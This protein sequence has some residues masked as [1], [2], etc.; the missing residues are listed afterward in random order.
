MRSDPE[1]GSISFSFTESEVARL[2]RFEHDR[3]KREREAQGWELGPERDDA[4]RRSPLLVDWD[5]LPDEARATTRRMIISLPGLIVD[6]GYQIARLG[7]PGSDRLWMELVAQAIH[8]RYLVR[9]AEDGQSAPESALVWESLSD[10]LKDSNRAQAADISRKLASIGCRIVPTATSTEFSG[11]T[12]TELEEL[13]RQ[14]HD[15]W[16]EERLAAGY[17]RGPRGPCTSPDLVGWEDLGE[18][19]RE[20]DRE[21]VRAIPDVLAAAGMAIERR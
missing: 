7:A 19:R 4:R 1:A 18:A 15:R 16:V 20:L 21:A 13:S 12:K 3:W 2:A 17:R 6:A 11:F 9:R 14:E 8:E 5:H 10:A